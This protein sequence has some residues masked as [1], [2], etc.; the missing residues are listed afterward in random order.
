MKR[1]IAA[2]GPDP[3]FRRAGPTTLY[4]R[5]VTV[6]PRALKRTSKFNSREWPDSPRPTAAS[7]VQFEERTGGVTVDVPLKCH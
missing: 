2:E 6:G 5:F 4:K 7:L 3:W 1:S